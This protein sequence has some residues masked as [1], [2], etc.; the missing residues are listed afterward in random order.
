MTIQGWRWAGVAAVAWMAGAA[1]A[2]TLPGWYG[3]AEGFGSFLDDTTYDTRFPPTMGMPGEPSQECVLGLPLGDLGL[4]DAGET[5]GLCFTI[6]GDPGSQEQGAP[7]QLD[8]QVKNG[9][10][11]GLLIGYGYESGLRPEL[12]L[13]YRRN[14]LESVRLGPGFTDADG[15]SLEG[16]PIDGADGQLESLSFMGNLWFDLKNSS[17]L[18]PYIGGG[19]GFRSVDLEI[20]GTGG[21]AG[22]DKD[23]VFAY[24]VGAGLSFALNT[25]LSLSLDGR[26][27]D[28]D[29]VTLSNPSDQPAEL[30]YKGAT[31]GLALRY[32]FAPSAAADSDGDGVP[33]FQDRCPNTPSGVQVDRFGCPL[34]SDGDG[35][36]DHL[37]ECP[38]TPAG[39]TVNAK[40]CPIDS[41]GDGVPDYLD[42]CPGTP[43]GMPV[44]A[45][46]CPIDSDGDG[47]PDHLDKCPS[48]PAGVE[49]GA[50]GCPAKDSDGDGIPDFR[51]LC[52][53][54]PEGIAIGADG[55]PLD[56]DGD[57]IPD[58]LDE[59]PQSPAGAVVLP[60]GCALVGDCRRPRPGEEVDERGCAV[61]TSFVL[62]GVKFE[63]DSAILT[64]EAKRILDRVSETLIAY[65]E[66]NVELEG[67]T[68]NIGTAAY[69]LGLSERRSITVKNYLISK[70]VAAERMVPVGYGLSQPIADNSTEEGRE[71]NRRVE[72][73]VRD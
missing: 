16:Q 70:G 33:D 32:V 63:F 5:L 19:L 37:D 50:D 42:K 45:E 29:K 1:S 71:E 58:Y 11:G 48:T 68:D 21:L 41:D 65:P 44:N 35:V 30:E 23:T 54:T 18:T 31:A 15:N 57:G 26:Y 17:R 72:L 53:D 66:I 55:C 25:R 67:H 12:A 13:S 6:P 69:N 39:A 24:Q 28:S 27:F 60:N 34:D 64:E 52:P 20:N 47:V 4:G 40:G 56:S 61:D 43:Q 2:Q 9:A 36:P 38:N 22:D 8:F 3:G 10:G 73:T 14:D 7:Y 46:G 62:K 51:D 49:V 59:C